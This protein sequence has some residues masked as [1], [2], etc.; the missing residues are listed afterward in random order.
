[1]RKMSSELN[2]KQTISNIEALFEISLE[3]LPKY[4]TINDVFKQLQNDII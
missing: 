3:E 2:T 4:D 1:M